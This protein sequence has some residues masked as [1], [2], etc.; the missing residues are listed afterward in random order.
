RAQLG[1]TLYCAQRL[2]PYLQTTTR[3]IHRKCEE[4]LKRLW[5]SLEAGKPRGTFAAEDARLL[6]ISDEHELD[7]PEQDAA[8]STLCTLSFALQVWSGDSS[9]KAKA[10]MNE[11][12]ELCAR[13]QDDD[14]YRRVE[15]QLVALVS[16]L[17][18]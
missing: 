8:V 9:S 7:R 5:A 11:L 10:A 2:I 16:S 15:G 14:R 13:L 18:A 1:L 17:P 12:L 6:S 3:E 4:M